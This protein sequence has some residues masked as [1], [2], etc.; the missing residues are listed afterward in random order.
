[1]IRNPAE[2]IRTVRKFGLFTFGTTLIGFIIRLIKSIVL[3]RILGPTGRGIY[4]LFITLP[5][6]MVSFGNLGI[7]LGNVYLVANRRYSLKKIFGN[8]LLVVLILGPILSWLGFIT[9]SRGWLLKGGEGILHQFLP[10]AL[11]AIPLILLFEFSTDLIVAIEDIHFVNILTLTASAFPLLLFI[12]IWL[13][14]RKPLNAAICAWFAGIVFV[15]LWAAF[16]V[17]KKAGF[18][19]GFSRSNLQEALSYGRRGFVNIFANQLVLRIDF[20]FV[21][22]MLGAKALGYYA[23][24]VSLVEILL[25]LPN[26]FN[27]PFLPVRLGMEDK[28]SSHLTPMVVRHV[29]FVMVIACAGIAITGKIV[30]WALFGK[31]FLPAYVPLLWLLPGVLFLSVYD[32]LRSDLYSH[33]MPGFVS[34]ASIVALTCNLILNYLL[35]PAYGISGAAISSSVAYGLSTTL[36]LLKHRRLSG[37]PYRE[38]L[39][40]KTTDLNFHLILHMALVIIVLM[41]F[42]FP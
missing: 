17:L 27:L 20:L 41:A 5:N 11:L 31:A 32:F 15:S 34:W 13:W 2:G 10:W 26:A 28:G 7:G 23:V 30:I 33:N 25:S 22:S 18:K 35:I 19:I 4:G 38:T 9:F 8:T 14:L 42:I 1:M 37:I 36:L 29:L 6:I 21:S 3:T 39:M 40:I 12:L 16:R 24:S